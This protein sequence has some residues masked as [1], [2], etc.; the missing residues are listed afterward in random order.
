MTLW[1]KIV[2]AFDAQLFCWSTGILGDE[3]IQYRCVEQGT[4][5]NDTG[6]SLLRRV[7]SP[8]VLSA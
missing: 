8:A 4:M 1:S 7:L 2:L 6:V 3:Q 5:R